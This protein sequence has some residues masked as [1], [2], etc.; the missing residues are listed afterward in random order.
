MT[1]SRRTSISKNARI[2]DRL[3]YKQ[4]PK[5]KHYKYYIQRVSLDE[6]GGNLYICKK[7]FDNIT[8]R[9]GQEPRWFRRSRGER[10]YVS[11]SVNLFRYVGKENNAIIVG[12]SDFEVGDRSVIDPRSRKTLNFLIYSLRNYDLNKLE[13][14]VNSSIPTETVLLKNLEQEYDIVWI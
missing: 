6:T 1:I 10:V 3:G 4:K 8:A 2:I 14:D 11:N 9:L 7:H 5:K 13:A 12:V